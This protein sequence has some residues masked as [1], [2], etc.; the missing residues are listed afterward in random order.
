MGL[1][2]RLANCKNGYQGKYH[3]VLTVCSAG[4]LRS[5][6]IAYVLGREPYNCNVRNCGVSSDYALIVIDEVLIEWADSI[7]YAEEEHGN[8]IQRLVT[9]KQI[10]I[11]KKKFYCLDLPDN[12]AYRDTELVLMI[13]KKLMAMEFPMDKTV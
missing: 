5:A 4:L 8:L 9:T 12:Y 2:N 11:S 1:M 7:V 3:K 10:D 6:T 13:E